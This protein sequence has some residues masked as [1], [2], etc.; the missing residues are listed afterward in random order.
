MASNAVESIQATYVLLI[1]MPVVARMVAS[2]QNRAAALEE[3]VAEQAGRRA[4][5]ARAAADEERRRIARELH[6]VI[7]HGVS[8]AIVQS[9]AT[10]SAIADGKTAD[11]LRRVDAI[12][13]TAR[14][15]LADMRRLVAVDDA[16]DLKAELG[17]QPGLGRLHDLVRMLV[18]TGVDA[19]LECERMPIGLSPGADLALFRIAQEALTNAI[20]HAP[21]APIRVRVAV[22]PRSVD[23]EVVNGEATGS[24]TGQGSGRGLIGIRQRVALYNG[25]MESGPSPDRGFR[26]RVSLPLETTAP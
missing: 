4:A 16:S 10:R 14:Q 15:T 26:V 25:E 2:R 23:L 19:A 17:P 8:V 7:A 24:D 11:A 22:T 9:M 20:N 6:D 21:G 18:D 5:A 3:E 13:E 12:E 1:A